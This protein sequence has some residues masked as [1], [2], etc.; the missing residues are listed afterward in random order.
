MSRLFVKMNGTGKLPAAMQSIKRKIFIYKLGFYH[1]SPFTS[2]RGYREPAAGKGSSCVI[3]SNSGFLKNTFILFE[4]QICPCK[5][6]VFICVILIE[7]RLV[8]SFLVSLYYLGL[9]DPEVVID[10]NHVKTITSYKYNEKNQLVKVVKKVQM[11][12]VKEQVLKRVLER[13]IVSVS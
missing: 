4:N 11:V 5:A 8:T 9:P 10:E 1:I 6:F 2:D 13:V 3:C 12:E 7:Q